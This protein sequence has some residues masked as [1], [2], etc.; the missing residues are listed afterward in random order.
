MK[1]ILDFKI[2]NIKLSYTK[3]LY[4]LMIIYIICIIYIYIK[5]LYFK[6]G[7]LVSIFEIKMKLEPCEPSSVNSSNKITCPQAYKQTSI[8]AHTTVRR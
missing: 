6:I 4:Y 5:Q 8:Q 7:H 2:N 1:E 3:Y